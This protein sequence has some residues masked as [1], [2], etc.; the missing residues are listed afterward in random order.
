MLG[1]F[2]L[3][4][5]ICVLQ[6]D[7]VK[8][9]VFD[10]ITDALCYFFVWPHPTALYYRC[11]ESQTLSRTQTSKSTHSLTIY[12]ECSITLTLSWTLQST[13]AQTDLYVHTHL[14]T[15][16]PWSA[17]GH[18]EKNQNWVWS[19][20]EGSQT[21]TGEKKFNCTFFYKLWTYGYSVTVIKKQNKSGL[22]FTGSLSLQ[23]F[24][25]IKLKPKQT[26]FI[27]GIPFT[28]DSNEI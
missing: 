3:T 21:V 18:N 25:L 8:S 17:L 27:D 7:S 15:C 9:I 13:T 19:R 10:C 2:T 14:P 26:V 6:V 20:A 11:P 1:I 16:D 24:Q 5:V 28:D 22:E 12:Y 4:E 23:W